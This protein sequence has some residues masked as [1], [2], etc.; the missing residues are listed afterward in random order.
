MIGRLL[1]A[2]LVVICT[3]S[4]LVLWTS[5]GGGPS[6]FRPEVSL[7]LGLESSCSILV[8][9]DWHISSVFVFYLFA[10][11]SD[12]DEKVNDDLLQLC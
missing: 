6:G 4:F 1:I 10:R 3:I 9:I 2:V 8:S 7:K 12:N 11:I 5:N